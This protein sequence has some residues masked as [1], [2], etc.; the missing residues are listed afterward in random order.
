MRKATISFVKCPSVCPH[1]TTLL[2][3]DG[4][5]WNLIF[6][7]LYEDQHTFVIISRSV[8]LRTNNVLGKISRENQNT[9][10]VFLP[11]FFFYR[12]VYEIMWENIVEPGRPDDNMAHA[13]CMPDT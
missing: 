12:V 2:P 11:C 6:G 4:F 13:H 5:L 1:A 8:F 7:T 10:F 9:N 3:R